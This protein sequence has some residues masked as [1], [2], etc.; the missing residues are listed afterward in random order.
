MLERKAYGPDLLHA[1]EGPSAEAVLVTP[2][3]LVTPQ[4][5]RDRCGPLMTVVVPWTILQASSRVV[6]TTTCVQAPR[7]RRTAQRGTRGAAVLVDRLCDLLQVGL[8]LLGRG[9]RGQG[10]VEGGGQGLGDGQL[11]QLGADQPSLTLE[12]SPAVHRVG[13]RGQDLQHAGQVQLGQR[14]SVLNA[15]LE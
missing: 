3:A 9:S 10:A 6:A 15:S 8:G 1:I 13:A 5:G 4:I 11:G 14:L 12:E 2:F 7:V